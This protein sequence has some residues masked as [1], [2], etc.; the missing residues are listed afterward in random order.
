MSEWSRLVVCTLRNRRVLLADGVII[1]QQVHHSAVFTF[2]A[3]HIDRF[4]S[5]SQNVA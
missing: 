4:D 3:A 5:G 1:I 2:S